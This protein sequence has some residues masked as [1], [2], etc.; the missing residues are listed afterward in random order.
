MQTELFGPVLTVARF[1]DE[2]EA[3]RLANDTRYGLAAGIFTRDLGRVHRLTP[4]IRAG[5]Q[6]VNCY[7]MGAPM[8]PIGGFGDSGKS[9]ESGLE[10]VK[11]YS[12]P[13]T[14]WINTEV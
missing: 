11:D 8:G 6:Y 14:V 9:R 3:L 10:A 2:A 5:I 4:R 1:K 7:R 13:I 12:K